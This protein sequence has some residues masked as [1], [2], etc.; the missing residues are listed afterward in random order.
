MPRKHVLIAVG[1]IIVSALPLFGQSAYLVKDVST[2]GNPESS[3]PSGMVTV[4]SKAFFSANAR[5][6]GS[7]PWVTDGTAAGTFMLRDIVVG[8]GSS[9]PSLFTAVGSTVFF[10]AL[11]YTGGELL[12]TDGTIGG[13]VPVKDFSGGINHLIALG[14]TLYFT[15]DDGV[16]GI[17]LWKSDG[18]EAGTVLAAD[19]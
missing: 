3:Y 19:I 2:S 17:E 11:T 5:G 1:L 14:G 9:Y 6:V 4:G 13:T 8:S 18:T 12:K 10:A 7:E 15:A 16:H